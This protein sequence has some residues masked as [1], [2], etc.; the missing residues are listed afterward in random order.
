MAATD[1]V[2]MYGTPT[3]SK[4]RTTYSKNSCCVTEEPLG[5]RDQ[6]LPFRLA[7][8]LPGKMNDESMVGEVM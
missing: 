2:I 7:R 3:A 5:N 4:V 8:V 1:P 6:D